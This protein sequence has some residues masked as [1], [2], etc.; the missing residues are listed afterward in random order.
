MRLGLGN[1]KIVRLELGN[2]KIVRLEL[3]N[4]KIV[5]LE[6]DNLKIVRLEL[7]NLKIVRFNKGCGKCY[8]VCGMVHIKEQPM[9]QQQVFFLTAFYRM[10]N[11]I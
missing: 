9:W 4:L 2:L 10:S 1:L 11:T 7:G 3:G 6:L 5:R 8:P